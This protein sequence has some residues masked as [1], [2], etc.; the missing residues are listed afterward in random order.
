MS[1]YRVE[2]RQRSMSG[3]YVHLGGHEHSASQSDWL[4]IGANRIGPI[5]F[6]LLRAEGT[7]VR[8]HRVAREE[9]TSD[10]ILDLNRLVEKIRRIDPDRALSKFRQDGKMLVWD[11]VQQLH[12][13]CDR[14]AC[15]FDSVRRWKS[16]TAPDL[17]RALLLYE[18]AADKVIGSEQFAN[19][20]WWRG[21]LMVQPD[22]V[23]RDL[24]N[25]KQRA[26]LDDVLRGV[27]D[28]IPVALETIRSVYSKGLHRMAAR[29]RHGATL[30]D[31]EMGFA[32]IGST[33]DEQ[34]ADG[35]ALKY[36]ALAVADTSRTDAIE[37]LMP[38]TIENLRG[39]Q[40][41][42]HEAESLM[43]QLCYAVTEQASSP[44]GVS[45]PIDPTIPVP[46]GSRQ[47][48]REAVLIYSDYDRDLAERERKRAEE[49]AA[50][51]RAVGKMRR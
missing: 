34:L 3:L 16:G 36:G 51:F 24:L 30:L 46:D 35:T 47:Q 20:A 2:V 48:L 6:A 7:S 13:V 25:E 4:R 21:V 11:Q 42:L 12:E 50:V 10:G 39:L 45:V 9:A 1:V 18:K 37:Y 32:W 23:R 31:P 22:T 27:D 26:L 41:C 5:A 43:W 28:H 38:L 19:Q 44:V 33:Q 49:T 15:V 8:T 29:Q 17:G 14:L 40:Q